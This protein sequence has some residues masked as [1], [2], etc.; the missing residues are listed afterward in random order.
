MPRNH[1][2]FAGLRNYKAMNTPG[3]EPKLRHTEL[4]QVNSA[5]L[6]GAKIYRQA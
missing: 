2:K 3:R 5:Q 4:A 1:I 6:V